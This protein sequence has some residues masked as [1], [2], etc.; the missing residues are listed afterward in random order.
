[1]TMMTMMTMM[2]I[3]SITSMSII[4]IASMRFYDADQ[5]AAHYDYGNEECMHAYVYVHTC[6]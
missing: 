1:M 3:I 4:I 6:I 2:T 5:Y